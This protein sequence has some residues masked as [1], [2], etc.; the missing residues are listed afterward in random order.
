M[1]VPESVKRSKTPWTISLCRRNWLLHR[2]VRLVWAFQ[3]CHLV[4]HSAQYQRIRAS[5]SEWSLILMCNQMNNHSPFPL[6]PDGWIFLLFLGADPVLSFT[7]VLTTEATLTWADELWLT[8]F[9]QFL[10]AGLTALRLQ[11]SQDETTIWRNWVDISNSKLILLQHS[12]F[13]FCPFLDSESQ[14]SWESLVYMI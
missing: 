12:Y 3:H 1:R 2:E 5:P 10:W 9:A 14:K 7:T 6:K 4:A 8:A 13:F 11:E